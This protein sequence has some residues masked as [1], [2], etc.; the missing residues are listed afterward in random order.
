MYTVS[1]GDAADQGAGD[2]QLRT[3]ADLSTV[4]TD[5]AC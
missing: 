4:M 3:F 1:I 5:L 2:A